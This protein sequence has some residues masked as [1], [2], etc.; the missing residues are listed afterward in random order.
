MTG[1]HSHAHALA[2]VEGVVSAIA[3]ADDP[4]KER[5][6]LVQAMIVDRASG[7]VRA[8]SLVEKF[9]TRGAC[10]GA[11]L[12][13]RPSGELVFQCID[14]D[15]VPTSDLLRIGPGGELTAFPLPKETMLLDAALGSN[16]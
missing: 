2:G 12:A 9:A 1:P 15:G 8:Q 5:R 13:R 6:A 10:E 4:T 16:T 3:V 7:V 11:R 14:G